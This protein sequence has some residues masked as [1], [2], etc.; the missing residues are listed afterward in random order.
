MTTRTAAVVLI[1]TVLAACWQ[2]SPAARRERDKPKDKPATEVVKYMGAQ[3][4][5]AWGRP[6][7]KLLLAPRYGQGVAKVVVP[8][9]D[10][11]AR[12]FDPSPAVV[13]VVKG[14]KPGDLVEIRMVKFRG[15][16][17]LRSIRRY[18]PKPGEDDPNAFAFVKHLTRKISGREYLAVVLKKA[19]RSQTILVP[20]R[21]NDEGKWV[22]DKDIA[23]QVRKLEADQIVE[24]TVKKTAGKVFLNSIRPYEP[25]VKGS[26]VKL[27]PKKKVGE[28]EYAAIAVKVAVTEQEILIPNRKNRA[29][30]T[31]PDPKLLAA[32]KKLKADQTV[33][34]KTLKEEG[35][36]WLVRI[37]VVKNQ[38][39][40]R[41]TRPPAR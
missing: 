13:K 9:K 27:I 24:I 5:S 6:V 40:P 39:S 31:L 7:M 34:F 22:P 11:M 35:Q 4:G 38:P 1:G 37:K 28:K 20:N 41:P 26:F 2:A 16:N 10:R 19:N 32:V 12:K 8:N 3:K 25:P 33:E 23:E 18:H 29:G 14:L 36:T 17:L 30:K 15:V 21:K